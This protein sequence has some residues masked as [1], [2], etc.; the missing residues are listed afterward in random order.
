M[1]DTVDPPW[2]LPFAPVAVF[3]PVN[4]DWVLPVATTVHERPVPTRT[5]RRADEVEHSGATA[6]WTSSFGTTVTGHIL[7]PATTPELASVPATVQR[8]VIAADDPTADPQPFYNLILG[9]PVTVEI[10]GVTANL[11]MVTGVD[12]DRHWVVVDLLGPML[13]ER[14]LTVAPA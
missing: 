14:G 9:S 3:G 10:D 8:V 11:G 5:V 13:S 6:T 4:G 2:S 12:P 1:P 7:D